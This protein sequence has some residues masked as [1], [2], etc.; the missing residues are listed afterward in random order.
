M[1]C[2]KLI[3]M[4]VEKIYFDLDDTLADFSLG[5]REICGI[6]PV[7]QGNSNPV[8]DDAMWEAVKNAEHFYL[9]LKE[10]SPGM[11]LFRKMRELYGNMVEILSAVPKARRGI[12]TAEEDKR[13]WVRE[14]IGEDIRVNITYSAEEKTKYACS[15]GC[16]LIDD[17]GKNVIS[18]RNAGGTAVRFLKKDTEIP[19]GLLKTD[20]SGKE[21][22]G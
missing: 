19:A 1:A 6:E 10:C 14:H 7:T 5:I 9:R 20:T 12:L 8:Q 3:G 21:E 22:M 18:W 15:E 13:Q 2:G 11:E 4:T 17:Y 16:I